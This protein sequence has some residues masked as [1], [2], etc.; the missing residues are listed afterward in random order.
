[1]PLLQYS[2]Q[3]SLVFALNITVF[4]VKLSQTSKTLRESAIIFYQV[5]YIF[6]AMYLKGVRIII[7]R[8]STR[9]AHFQSPSPKCIPEPEPRHHR[10][11]PLKIGNL[12]EEQTASTNIGLRIC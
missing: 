4:S 8:L 6:I 1:M 9:T 12:R 5:I 7:F 3:T 2:L 10:F 11:P